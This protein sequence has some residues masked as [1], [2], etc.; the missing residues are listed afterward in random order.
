MNPAHPPTDPLEPPSRAIGAKDIARYRKLM[1]EQANPN[2]GHVI[3]GPAAGGPS[4]WRLLAYGSLFLL[5]VA[6]FVFLFVHFT[7]SLRVA[8]IV[9]ALMLAYML[10]MARMAEGSLD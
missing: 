7:S 8:L 2:T 6:A 9:V 10:F 1:H 3:S 5:V 4:L